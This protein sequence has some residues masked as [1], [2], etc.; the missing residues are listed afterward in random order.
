MK[1]FIKIFILTGLTFVFN[2]C[3]SQ[4]SRLTPNDFEKAIS[5]SNVQLID[6]RTPE[7]FSRGHIKNAKNIDFYSS[8]FQDQISKLDKKQPLYIYCA[9]GNRSGQALKQLSNLS[10]KEF[11]DL[12]GGIKAWNQ[13]QKKIIN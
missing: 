1:K 2:S 9:S 6:I 11:G 7:E 8:N 5:K 3:Q 13:A 10:F 4:P 12:E